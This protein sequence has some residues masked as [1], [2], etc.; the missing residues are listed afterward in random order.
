MPKSLHLSTAINRVAYH[1]RALR[2]M[3]A[4]A[5]LQEMVAKAGFRPDQPR[6]PRGSSEGGR[7]TNKPWS[8]EREPAFTRVGGRN[9]F[10]DED[11]DVPWDDIRDLVDISPTRPDRLSERYRI[12]RGLLVP[13]K[14]RAP[15][16]PVSEMVERLGAPKWLREYYPHMDA[17]MSPAKSLPQLQRDALSPARGYDIHHIV[18]RTGAL[19]DG[20]S[21]STVDGP[22][23]L[24]RIPKFRH[25][26]LTSKIMRR[27]KALGLVSLR[28]H[29]R[30][31]DWDERFE[32]GLQLLRDARVLK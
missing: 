12:A 15:K 17:Y 28:D 27:D 1:A 11:D 30:G 16:R 29:L 24:V 21:R 7:W 10:D 2:V 5:T 18:E 20:F 9:L 4:V 6:V 26:D 31:R 14:G 23:N 25:W 8:R 13:F 3:R 32:R 22:D 19:R